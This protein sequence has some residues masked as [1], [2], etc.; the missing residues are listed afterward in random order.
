MVALAQRAG[1]RLVEVW[2]DE[3]VPIEV[4]NP[5]KAQRYRNFMNPSGC[6]AMFGVG[7]RPAIAAQVLAAMSPHSAG[8]PGSL[9]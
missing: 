7:E 2:L 9:R 5:A 1:F 3:T 4:L 6:A 8:C